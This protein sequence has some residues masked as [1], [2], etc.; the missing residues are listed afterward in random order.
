MANPNSSTLFTGIL[1]GSSATLLL[2][3]V[4]TRFAERKN[5]TPSSFN[6]PQ[7]KPQ[8]RR[9]QQHQVL[10]PSIRD[11]QLSRSTLYFG[12]ENMQKL[13]KHSRVCVVGL[14][15][16]GSHA[17]VALARAGLGPYLRL[18]D[19]D[20]VTL[21]SLNRHACATLQDVGIPKVTCV[22]ADRLLELPDGEHWDMI[23]D[24]IDDVPTKAELIQYCLKHKIPVVSCMSAGGKADVTRLHISDLQSAAKDPLATKLRQTLK[25]LMKNETGDNDD[26]D[27]APS[28]SSYLEDMDR[29]SILYS[30]EKTV[31]KL[32]ALTPE[33][34]AAPHTFGAMDHMRVRVVPVLG[35]MPAI[36]GLS[37]AAVCMTRLGQKPLQPVPGERIG[38]SVRHRMLQHLK[39]REEK[40]QKHVLAKA[41]LET[42]PTANIDDSDGNGDDA[43]E[44][45]D[46]HG[47]MVDGTWIGR[48]QV[49]MDDIDFLF[50]IWRNR[51]AVTGARLGTTLALVRWNMDKP[52]T[53]D[54]IVLMSAKA[55]KLFDKPNGK[56]DIPEAVQRSIE[57][58]LE[59]CRCA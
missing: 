25:R 56:S 49:D 46:N 35:T 45:D 2:T 7:Q 52:S 58:R 21:S 14:G 39:M 24:A 4:Y 26:G 10:P 40:I 33:Q 43:E 28:S 9:Q 3:W 23:I 44:S 18:I 27:D 42:L 22:P 12:Q 19:F 20:Q 47:C 29:L 41:G 17:A 6:E 32:A 8:R 16:V 54:N 30:S 59:T 5:E 1:I 13:S 34:Q 38:R 53:C 15:G 31:T 37:L 36:M 51:C 11:E 57:E 55:M 50:E 48:V